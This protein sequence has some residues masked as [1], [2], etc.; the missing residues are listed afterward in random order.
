MTGS[1]VNGDDIFVP[2]LTQQ[3][4]GASIG[5]LWLAIFQ[6]MRLFTLAFL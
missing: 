1:K 4:Y 6:Q 2:D 5:G 3:Q